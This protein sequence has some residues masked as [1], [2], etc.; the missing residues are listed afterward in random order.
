MF[1]QKGLG[2]SHLADDDPIR[3]ESESGSEELADG[4]L[5]HALGVGGMSLETDPM[6][7]DR[8]LGSIFD[9]HDSL[10]CRYQSPKDIEQRRLARAGTAR[11]DD[12]PVG[13]HRLTETLCLLDGGS[14]ALDELVQA[15]YRLS[16]T[17][18]G[19]H[20]MVHRG[21]WDHYVQPASVGEPCSRHRRRSVNSQAQ[22]SQHAINRSHQ[23]TVPRKRHLHRLER[24][25][26]LHPD[27]LSTVDQH[28]RDLRVAEKGLEW[29][30]P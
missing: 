5:S 16:E 2:T 8:E 14:L 26:A 19:E 1:G 13:D 11:D 28:V 15:A 25:A 21:R 18:N 7:G 12:G 9:G 3:P 22:R 6:P 20:R 10:S 30:Q 17:A 23:G 4:D 24:T 27:L 29:P